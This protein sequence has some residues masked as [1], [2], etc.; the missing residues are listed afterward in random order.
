MTNYIGLDAHSKTCTFV[1]IDHYG[2][3]Q[4]SQVVRTSE[5]E[6]IGFLRQ[7]KGTK[8]LTFE[9]STLAKWLHAIIK[10]EVDELTVCNPLYL[11]RKRGAKN[12]FNDA[13]HLA[14]QLRGGLLEPVYHS[15]HEFIKL[16]TLVSGYD[17]LNYEIIRT[18]VR[19]SALLRSQA[20]ISNKKGS[21]DFYQSATYQE[22][23][24]GEAEKFLAK[25]LLKRMS[26]LDQCRR[27]FVKEFEKF[28]SKFPEVKALMTVPGIALVRAVSI[29]AHVCTP[30]RFP[31]KHHFWSYCGLVSHDKISDGK[32]YGKIRRGGV[33]ELKTVFIGA[34]ETNMS[35]PSP[36]QDYYESLIK[37]G[38]DRRAARRA[39]ARKLATAALSIMKTKKVFDPSHIKPFA[40]PGAINELTSSV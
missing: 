32:S 37:Q 33:P 15:D 6:I 38:L 4:R 31:N 27:Q 20:I 1:V 11:N 18:K 10:P 2:N 7:L 5:A 40:I 12:D 36:F 17:D 9:E 8:L 16:R 19:Y 13:L 39:V 22:A 26:Y 30:D 23:L 14:H 21:K 29:V 24:Q 35:R 28:G 25:Q 34:A 3:E